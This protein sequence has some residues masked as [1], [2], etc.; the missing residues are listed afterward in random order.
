MVE[1][2]LKSLKVVPFMEE[3]NIAS[4]KVAVML[5]VVET[6]VASAVGEVLITV[7]AVSGGGGSQPPPPV[8]R[9][10]SVTV[11]PCSTLKPSALNETAPLDEWVRTDKP[12]RKS[13]LV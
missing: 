5:V 10:Q 2:F 11:E 3:A 9:F 13:W 7:G 1:P 12:G 8:P 4:E 6:L